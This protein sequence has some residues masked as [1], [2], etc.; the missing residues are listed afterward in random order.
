MFGK[1]HNQYSIL[2]MKLVNRAERKKSNTHIER[3]VQKELEKLDIFYIS[4]KGF[5]IRDFIHPVDIFI[6]Q[7]FV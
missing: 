6:L 2:K 1:K 3:T 7:I 5:K 4:Q